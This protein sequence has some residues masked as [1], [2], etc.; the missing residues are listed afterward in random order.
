MSV[1]CLIE[2]YGVET[3]PLNI[4]LFETIAMECRTVSPSSQIDDET[5]Q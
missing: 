2:H 4:Q 1:G 3:A 5:I